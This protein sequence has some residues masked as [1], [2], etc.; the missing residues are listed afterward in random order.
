MCY[1]PEGSMC[2]CHVGSSQRLQV[3]QLYNVTVGIL[4]TGVGVCWRAG[5]WGELFWNH[6]LNYSLDPCN[7]VLRGPT[8]ST[9][10]QARQSYRD[11]WSPPWHFPGGASGKEPIC[12]SLGWEDPLQEGTAAHP[13]ILA[14]RIPRAEKPGGLQSI[15]LQR[16]RHD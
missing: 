11:K 16:V 1:I 7:S 6:S 3:I 12:Q 14:W 10:T 5:Q 15:G 2:S 9:S 13:N 4:D 8:I